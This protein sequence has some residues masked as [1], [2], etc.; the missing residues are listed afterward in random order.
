MYPSPQNLFHS[1]LVLGVITQSAYGG[2]GGTILV[3][4]SRRMSESLLRS[5]CEYQ[6]ILFLQ[7]NAIARR[8]ERQRTSVQ[9][10]SERQFTSSSSSQNLKSSRCNRSI[11]MPSIAIPLTSKRENW[12][13]KSPHQVDSCTNAMRLSSSGPSKPCQVET[14]AL[15]LL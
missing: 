4:H 3:P 9:R 1:R 14:W 2:Y 7:V 10:A 6:F 5:Q 8:C 12:K 13:Q 11:E 15:W